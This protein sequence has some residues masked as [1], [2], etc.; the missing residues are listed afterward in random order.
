MVGAGT[1]NTFTAT[2]ETAEV[3]DPDTATTLYVPLMSA[4]ALLRVT[5][6]PVALYPEGPLQIK[7]PPEIGETDKLRFCPTQIGE[8]VAI[9]GGL[10]LF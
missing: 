7:V 3:Q 4:V 5:L 1:L 8:L 2:V 9:T 10:V 6:A